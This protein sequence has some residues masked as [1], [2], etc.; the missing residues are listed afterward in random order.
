VGRLS[1]ERFESV[2]DPEPFQRFAE[3]VALGREAF[4][5]RIIWNVNST[6]L[7]GGVAEMLQ[8]LLSYARGAGV[9][10][11]WM[12]IEGNP[13]FFAITK[14]IHNLLHG[15]PGDGGALGPRERDVYGEVSD[16]N[17]Q[18]LSGLVRPGDVVILHDPQTAGVC[19]RMVDAGALVIWRCHVG[20]DRA[21][22]HVREA[23]E[24]LRPHVEPAMAYVF[25]RLEYAWS[26]LDRDRVVVIPPSI[27]AFSPKNQR[28]DAA[29]TL[30]ILATAGLVDAGEPGA[31]PTFERADGSRGTVVRRAEFHGR[32]GPPSLLDRLVVQ[33]SR[34]DRLKD[35]VGVI[36]A[37]AE[38]VTAAA[39]VGLLLAG[40]STRA[41]A[42]D[43]EGA[44]VLAEATDALA[45]LAPG[46]QERV[47]L[48]SLP[49]DDREENAAIVNALQRHATVVVQKSL[50]EGFGLTVAEAMWKARPVVASR[51]GGI[52][53]Q[54]VDGETG[55][56]VDPLNGREFGTAVTELLNDVPRAE[57]MGSRARERVRA[58][59]LGPRHLLQ[60][61]DLI[62]RLSDEH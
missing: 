17:G 58:E 43:P 19:R 46:V 9:D 51:I 23:W 54:I 55:M 59:Y 28:L 45:A 49:M 25:S 30:S 1:P 15:F 31:P 38:H 62:L 29:M 8:S 2:L 42:D 26:G 48:V 39:D 27:D 4:A 61:L 53:D 56:L 12:V 36:Q 33:V 60:Y 34:W 11:R 22:D 13:E 35:P 3:G 14:R 50:A 44:E 16:R 47:H 24:F 57:H 6:A 5:G 37:F 21:N 18:E 52:R 40:P 32:S 41:V 20:V 10:A 7:G